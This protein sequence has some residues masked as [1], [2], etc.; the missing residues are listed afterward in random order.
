VFIG[1]NKNKNRQ[2]VLRVRSRDEHRSSVGEGSYN[3]S[4]TD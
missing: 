2:K 1:Q 3:V 4:K